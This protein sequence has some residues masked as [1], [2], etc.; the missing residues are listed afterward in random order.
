MVGGEEREGEKR[1]AGRGEKKKR[2]EG[3]E[4]GQG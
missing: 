3:W 4:K 2:R 1:R